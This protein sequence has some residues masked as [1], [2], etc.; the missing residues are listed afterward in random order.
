[1]SSSDLAFYLALPYEYQWETREEE[2]LRYF[3]VRVAEI[4]SVVGGGK[5]KD[6]ARRAVRTA[7]EDYLEWR[8]E[9]HLPI[10]SPRRVVPRAF[11][12]SINVSLK[13]FVVHQSSPLSRTSEQTKST[14]T[15]AEA[16]QAPVPIA[17]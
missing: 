6:E 16:F 17:A 8:I 15:R 5:T 10:A 14:R 9:D 4:P 7:F 2:G 12:A 11:E 1:M 13:R 3:T